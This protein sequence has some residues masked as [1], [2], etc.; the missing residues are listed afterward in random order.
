MCLRSRGCFPTF[1]AKT[2]RF[3]TEFEQWTSWQLTKE[4]FTV[5]CSCASKRISGSSGF[6]A[7]GLCIV[8]SQW[9]RFHEFLLPSQFGS[10]GSCI[11][12]SK[13]AFSVPWKVRLIL[14]SSIREQVASNI[15]RK[16]SANCSF[17]ARDFGQHTSIVSWCREWRSKTFIGLHFSTRTSD[18]FDRQR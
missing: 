17:K 2:A 10:R 15:L 11:V 8:F 12:G 18:N 3:S 7:L 13:T 6:Q 1:S 14:L 9:Q 16:E 5:I 4:I